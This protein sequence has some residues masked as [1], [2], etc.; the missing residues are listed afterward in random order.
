[1]ARNRSIP[2]ALLVLML[3]LLL[4]MSASAAEP[5]PWL[6]IHSTHFTVITDAGE[7]KALRLRSASSRCGPSSPFC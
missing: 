2:A 6:E 4:A 1:M 3:V 7:K 5:S